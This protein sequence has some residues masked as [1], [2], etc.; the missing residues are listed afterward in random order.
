M[1][2]LL[3]QALSVIPGAAIT[4]DAATACGLTAAH[5]LATGVANGKRSNLEVY[6]FRKDGALYV[7]EY[8][9]QE[10]VPD[11]QAETL[12][13]SHCSSDEREP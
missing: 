13:L 1:T 6:A 8:T 9:F 2:E 3:S 11:A 5:L 12:L 10:K 7:L 4:R